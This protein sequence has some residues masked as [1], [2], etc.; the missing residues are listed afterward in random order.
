MRNIKRIPRLVFHIKR[1]AGQDERVAGF[2][3]EL[4][5]RKNEMKAAGHDDMLKTLLS[6]KLSS[7]ANEDSKRLQ[8]ILDNL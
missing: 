2:Q 8:D 5:R 1:C 4:N 6:I 3:D 7:E